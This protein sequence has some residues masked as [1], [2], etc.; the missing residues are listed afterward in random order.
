MEEKCYS[1]RGESRIQT[2][3]PFL[4]NNSAVTPTTPKLISKDLNKQQNI[5]F[6]HEFKESVKVNHTSVFAS[7]VLSPRDKE[8]PRKIAFNDDP[9]LFYS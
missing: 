4:S 7:P 9:N 5:G 1:Q 8:S 6:L 3:N 2:Q